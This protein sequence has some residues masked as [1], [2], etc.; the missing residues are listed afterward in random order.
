M[1]DIPL[2]KFLIQRDYPKRSQKL[3]FDTMEYPINIYK[4]VFYLDVKSKY[5][6]IVCTCDDCTL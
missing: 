2:W 3:N 5:E 1:S 4:G 6:Y